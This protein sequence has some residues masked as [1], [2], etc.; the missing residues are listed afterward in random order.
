VSIL[1]ILF[2][3]ISPSLKSIKH[4]STLIH[5]K[6]NNK[7]LIS[8]VL[9]YTE[10]FDGWLPVAAEFGTGITHGTMF[11]VYELR[12]YL[13]ILASHTEQIVAKNTVTECPASEFDSLPPKYGGYGYNYAYLGY[14]VKHAFASRKNIRLSNNPKET[15]TLSDSYSVKDVDEALLPWKFGYIYETTNSI[16]PY[17]RHVDSYNISWLDG[18]VSAMIWEEIALGKFSD[19]NWYFKLTK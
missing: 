9:L 8:G 13:N 5:C 1:A 3:L 7:N 12:D 17:R 10:D 4:Q 11:W 15:I 19:V 18:H 2:S 6:N 14:T 16:A